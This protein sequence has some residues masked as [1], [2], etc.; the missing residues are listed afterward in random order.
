MP[1]LPLD[2]NEWGP[3]QDASGPEDPGKVNAPM[4]AKDATT[5]NQTVADQC[6]ITP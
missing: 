5:K 3:I 6:N 2:E 4:Q 1:T